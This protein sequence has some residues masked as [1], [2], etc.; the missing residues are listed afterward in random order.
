MK[1]LNLDAFAKVSR[2]VT[3]FGIE[4]KVEEMT[5]ENFIETTKVAEAL[6]KNKSR[7]VADEI[8]ASIDMIHR[9]IPT[10][11]KADLRRLSLEQLAII[12]RFLRGDD[13]AEPAEEGAEGNE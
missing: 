3:L 4:H 13:I 7:T 2:T 11:D 6:E 1:T 10:V 12:S 9:S 5:V 8:E